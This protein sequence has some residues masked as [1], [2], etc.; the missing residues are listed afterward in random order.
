LIERDFE[1]ALAAIPVGY[2]EGHYSGKRYGTSVKRSNDGRRVSLFAEELA[3]TDR[4][5][6]NFFQLGPGRFALKPCEMSEAKVVDFV[7]GFRN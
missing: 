4:I 6:F 3:G 5:S 2:S 1:T 7:R